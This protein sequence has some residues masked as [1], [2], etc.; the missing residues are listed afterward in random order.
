M[1]VVIDVFPGDRFSRVRHNEII[2]PVDRGKARAVNPHR[3]CSIGVSGVPSQW[4]WR[5]A[6]LP[7][8]QLVSSAFG[9]EYHRVRCGSL[10]P[11]PM[12]DRFVER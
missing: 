6:R 4:V 1:P 5:I 8:L 11:D 12:P 3:S 9:A 10:P 7:C 2:V